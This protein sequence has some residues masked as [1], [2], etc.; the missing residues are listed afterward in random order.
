[1]MVGGR[2][3][4]LLGPVLL[5]FEGLRRD[6]ELRVELVPASIVIRA[7]SLTAENLGFAEGCAC[8]ARGD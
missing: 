5:R 7:E 6:V 4:G 1:M 2:G 8:R 3:W